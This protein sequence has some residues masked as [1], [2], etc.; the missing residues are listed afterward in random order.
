MAALP[1]L[2]SNPRRAGEGA[3]TPVDPDISAAKGGNP[4]P[5][6][7]GG[8][9][10]VGNKRH[11][12]KDRKDD[13]YE[14]PEEATRALLRAET[15]PQHI[16]EP[17]AGRRAIADILEAAGHQVSC[18]DLVE[19]NVPGVRAGIDFLMEQEAW[20]GI[21]CI[22]TNPPFKLADEFI[23]HGLRLCPK[24]IMLLRYVYHEGI[25]KSDII[26]NNLTRVWLGRERLPM[27][28]RDGW[29]GKKNTNAGQPFAWFVF[30]RDHPNPGGW[31]TR[32]IS[33]REEEA[34]KFDQQESVA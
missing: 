7:K 25:N 20:L 19:R 28:H 27:M 15:L 23:R 29:E 33:W 22:V 3:P 6:S 1:L 4:D 18:T 13:L 31:I 8:N 10:R 26:D 2:R 32:R 34:G 30:E 17:A 5:S 11:A 9:N 12:L 16:W 14:T 21:D 24:V